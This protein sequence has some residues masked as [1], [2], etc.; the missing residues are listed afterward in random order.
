MLGG[1][2]D[3]AVEPAYRPA[4]EVEAVEHSFVT[5]RGK[6]LELLTVQPAE[7]NQSL[8]TGTPYYPESTTI[9]SS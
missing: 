8:H 7:G 4:V 2:V 3:G 9:T 5:K 6:E 1:D